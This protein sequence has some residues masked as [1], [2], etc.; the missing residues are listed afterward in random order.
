MPFFVGPA[1]LG[2]R[3]QRDPDRDGD[4][5]TPTY[6]E[7]ERLFDR[8]LAAFGALDTVEAEAQWTAGAGEMGSGLDCGW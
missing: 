4:W 3:L 1:Y 7:F 2:G 8:G 5:T 6:K